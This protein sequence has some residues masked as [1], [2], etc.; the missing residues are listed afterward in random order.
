MEAESSAD[1][2]GGADGGSEL[3]EVGGA[4]HRWREA[5]SM[6]AASCVDGRGRR[7]WRGGEG[8]KGT[9]RGIS[10]GRNRR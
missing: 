8:E 9:E 6:E 4:Q 1:G 3:M 10:S 7:Q 5:A 2:G